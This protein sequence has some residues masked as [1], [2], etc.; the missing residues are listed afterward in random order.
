MYGSRVYNIY[1]IVNGTRSGAVPVFRLSYDV[2]PEEGGVI[3]SRYTSTIISKGVITLMGKERRAVKVWSG[4]EA[5]AENPYD[6]WVEGIGPLF[7]QITNYN[8]HQPTGIMVFFGNLYYRVL[9]CYDGD[10]KIYDY[11]EFRHELYKPT[12]IFSD[13]DQK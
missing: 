7:G 5:W 3:T 11:R 1:Y 4:D 6:Y 8:T 10:E 2:D 12:E 9:E 13:A